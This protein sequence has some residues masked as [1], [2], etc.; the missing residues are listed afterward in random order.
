M[1]V[2]RMSWVSNSWQEAGWVTNSLM[3][4]GWVG[5]HDP[6]SIVVIALEL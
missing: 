5:P 3:T 4:R 2:V 1:N 6:C